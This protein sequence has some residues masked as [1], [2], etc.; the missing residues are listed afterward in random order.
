MV[1]SLWRRDRNRLD[2]LE[3]DDTCSYRTASFFMTMQEV[4]PLLMIRSS[5]AA[6]NER[7]WNI[8]R[9][10]PDM[11]PWDYDLFAKV[12]EPLWG[13]RYNTRECW[14]NES[15]RTP[16]K[17][18][19]ILVLSTT[20]I[21][22]SVPTIN[23]CLHPWVDQSVEVNYVASSYQLFGF[24]LYCLYNKRELLVKLCECRQ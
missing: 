7:I 17:I 10:H 13:T 5:C 14:W 3:N 19:K 6:D 24:I 8:H 18:P 9:T 22:P 21:V 20:F 1:N 12:K 23:S 2:S 4:T 16:R 11:R 15:G